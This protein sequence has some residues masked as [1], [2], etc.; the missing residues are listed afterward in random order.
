MTPASVPVDG[1]PAEQRHAGAVLADDQDPRVGQLLCNRYQIRARGRRR[2]MGRVYE[3][4]DMQARR[5]VALKVLHPD[6]A[7]D[8]IGRRALQNASS[9]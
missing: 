7:R 1:S 5:N 8:S 6:V 4:L 9:T 2:G 3:A